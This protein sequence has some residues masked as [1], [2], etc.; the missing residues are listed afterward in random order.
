LT[1]QPTYPL[2]IKQPKVRFGESVSIVI[3]TGGRLDALT[4]CLESLQEF[5]GRSEMI[6][7]GDHGDQLTRRA[8]LQRFPSVIY[9]ESKE[10]SAIVKRNLGIAHAS[11]EILV[12]VDDDVV[13]EGSWLQNLIRHYRDGSVGGVGGRVKVPGLK[14][15][16]SNYKTGT[17][18]DG[19][20]IGN[21]N[22][23]TTQPSEVKHLLGCNMSFRKAPV[24]KLGGFDNFFR[25]SN[26]REET[27]L[28]LRMGQLGY[29]LIFDPDASV[30]H[31]AL[32]GR[33]RGTRWI[34]YYVRNT[35]YLYL[36]YQVKCGPSLV[37]FFRQLVFPPRDYAALSGVSVRISPITMLVATSGIVAGFLG[38][39]GHQG[40]TT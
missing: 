39:L 13:I 31:K 25:S 23:P 16:P 20:V 30:L 34:F 5:A 33:T 27:D 18:V 12:F 35:V 9:L 19:F 17:I 6:V 3:P 40:G 32:G 24:L 38:Y 28:C 8:L 11:N 29:R 14:T 4:E 15:G 37:R 1:A 26:F 2:S 22:P 36:K 7:I 10:S 21:W